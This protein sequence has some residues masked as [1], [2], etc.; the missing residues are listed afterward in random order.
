MKSKSSVGL[1][2]PTWDVV[3]R[4]HD[5]APIFLDGLGREEIDEVLAAATLRRLRED[6]VIAREGENADEL[7]LILEGRAR[8]FTMTPEGKKIVI[9][10]LHPGDT[11]GGRA[12]LTKR[13]VKYLASTEI[14]AES[15]ALVWE[16]DAILPLTRRYPRLLENG[17]QIASDYL[18]V[19]RDLHIASCYSK[20]DE[21]VAWVLKKLARE[22]GKKIDDGIELDLINEEVANEAN[23]T[24]FTV[25][26]LLNEWQRKGLLV[27][28]RGKIVIRSQ[29]GLG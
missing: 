12:L 27:K 13:P 2:M 28:E 10:W 26:R 5:L 15:S 18:A 22:I 19:Y 23:V 25:S 7:F 29:D 9:M 16:H 1:A 11:Y 14:V 17:L 24:I 4:V 21:R 8:H 3:A 20:A 6:S